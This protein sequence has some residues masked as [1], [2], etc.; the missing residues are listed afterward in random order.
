MFM[1]ELIIFM[2]DIN[3]R[4]VHILYLLVKGNS[5]FYE[6]VDYLASFGFHVSFLSTIVHLNPAS[7][8]QELITNVVTCNT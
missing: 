4:V 6:T 5:L 1:L 8:V 2:P 7:V 3:S